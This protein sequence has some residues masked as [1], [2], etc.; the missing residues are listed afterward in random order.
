MADKIYIGDIGVTF[1]VSTGIDL[2][3]AT[4]TK[5][6]VWTPKD[7]ALEW[8]ATV[9]GSATD[10]ILEYVNDSDDFPVAGTYKLQAYVELST[11]KKFYG[12][13]TTFTVYDVYN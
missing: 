1:R 2:S 10:G 6:K 5:L 4:V 8:T 12:E 7:S 13:T 3:T 9:Y 11:G